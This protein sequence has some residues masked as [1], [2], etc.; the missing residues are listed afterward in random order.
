M[1]EIYINF[2][3]P[4]KLPTSGI[5]IPA[6]GHN[7]STSLDL[8]GLGSLK[9]SS[10]L[11][12]N[13][14]RLCENFASDVP[15][16]NPT[17]GQL[18]YN[19]SKKSISVARVIVPYSALPPTDE[20][21]EWTAVGGVVY[22]STEPILNE[23][24]SPPL[25]TNTHVLW[26]DTIE[27]ILKIYNGTEFI[28]A[29][30]TY[31]H[32]SGD[33]IT[34]D[35]TSSSLLAN[36]DV[37]VNATTWNGV[38]FTA[39]MTTVN[40]STNGSITNNT[41]ITLVLKDVNNN[42]TLIVTKDVI[43]DVGS[44]AD[45]T[46][47]FAIV[48]NNDIKVDIS[49]ERIA[50]RTVVNMNN[51]KII[52]VSDPS[53]PTSLVPYKD[54][55]NL[56]AGMNGG[57]VRTTGSVMTGPMNITRPRTTEGNSPANGLISPDLTIVNSGK[58]ISL[59]N[60]KGGSLVIQKTN[61]DLLTFSRFNGVSTTT[62]MDINLV[63]GT[64]DAYSNRIGN[65]KSDSTVANLAINKKVTDEIINNSLTNTLTTDITKRSVKGRITFN[66]LTGS[67]IDATGCF[68]TVTKYTGTQ[69]YFYITTTGVPSN[70]K[71]CHIASAATLLPPTEGAYTYVNATIKYTVAVAQIQNSNNLRLY[72]Y[73]VNK[74][75]NTG[76][77]DS[78]W[79]HS[80][81]FLNIPITIVAYY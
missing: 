34:G 5:T 61:T 7:T 18:W 44:S 27:G 46:N 22:S 79:T 71:L 35:L 32:L 65:L 58:T 54:I 60:N 62:W 1:N 15:P 29:L 3:N 37:V 28:D 31:V 4:D 72:I 40:L 43:V 45:T 23:N 77:L 56:G 30:E 26:F 38:T 52:N 41:D 66:G 50:F 68:S 73:T 49:K 24:A 48:C 51:H 6:K 39:P 2:S 47:T 19:P 67:I 11:Q 10:A 59:T 78:S 12:Q 36:S 75:I 69:N 81:V 14:L 55:Y 8:Y 53:D 74:T 16:R 42:T 13:L 80:S 20:V 17:E 76:D 21:L 70:T 33:T 9:Y 64:I 63:T 57:F 25:E